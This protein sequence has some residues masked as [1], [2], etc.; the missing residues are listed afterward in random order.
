MEAIATQDLFI[1]HSYI[2]IA[3]SN[4]DINVMDR[5]PFLRDMIT[6]VAPHVKFTINGNEHRMA[7]VLADGIYPEWPVFVKTFKEPMQAKKVKF[8]TLQE[9]ARKDVERCFGVLQ[10][11]FHYLTKPCLLHSHSDMTMVWEACVIIHNMIIEWNRGVDN[12]Q[13]PVVARFVQQSAFNRADPEKLTFKQLSDGI[14]VVS[15]REQHHRLRN[16]LIAHIWANSG[17]EEA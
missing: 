14:E 9:A 4:N 10:A 15:N 2:G 3:G 17:E 13:I 7:Y 8:A 11:R 12:E 6:G 1:Y 5:S 16:D